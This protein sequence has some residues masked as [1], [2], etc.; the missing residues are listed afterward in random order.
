MEGEDGQLGTKRGYM[1]SK[2]DKWDGLWFSG[3]L[4][5]CTKHD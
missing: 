4:A 5:H 3:S 1:K 2:R